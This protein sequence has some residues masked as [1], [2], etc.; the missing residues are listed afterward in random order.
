MITKVSHVSLCLPFCNEYKV[1]AAVGITCINSI[2]CH[3]IFRK[4]RNIETG[5]IVTI[6][7]YSVFVWG[8]D[9]LLY[10]LIL[11]FMWPCKSDC[12]PFFL[13]CKVPTHFLQ[14]CDL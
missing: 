1:S 2:Y 8:D 6:L 11:R 12:I 5:S 14:N 4:L 7:K 13:K 10:S 9:R 3:T